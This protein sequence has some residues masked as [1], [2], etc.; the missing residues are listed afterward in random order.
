MLTPTSGADVYT[1]DLESLT[2][3]KNF[4]DSES[5][6]CFETFELREENDKNVEFWPM[7]VHFKYTVVSDDRVSIGHMTGYTAQAY[8]STAVNAVS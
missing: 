5:V 3:V 4:A 1:K 7:T 2:C 8:P 6:T